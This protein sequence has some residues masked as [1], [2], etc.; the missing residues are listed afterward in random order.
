M[1]FRSFRRME[2]GFTLSYRLVGLGVLFFL[3]GRNLPG[4]SLFQVFDIVLERIPTPYNGRPSSSS[5]RTST[6]EERCGLEAGWGDSD[7]RPSS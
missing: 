4:H 3:L 2:H 5:A 6:L 7:L 1:G